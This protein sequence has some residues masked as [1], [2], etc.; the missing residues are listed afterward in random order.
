MVQG[1][2]EKEKERGA[3]SETLV[4]LE[5]TKLSDGRILS[6]I[7]FEKLENKITEYFSN[8]PQPPQ[9]KALS[10]LP[11]L[12]EGPFIV[13]EAH[14]DISPKKF[15]IENMKKFKQYGFEVLFLEHLFYDSDQKDLD[16]FFETG[17]MSLA[18]KSR[19]ATLDN[20]GGIHSNPPDPEIPQ[21]L[22]KQNNYTA[23]VKAAQAAG[24]RIVGAD[25]S[26]LYEAQNIENKAVLNAGNPLDDKRTAYGNYGISQTISHEIGGSNEKWFALLGNTHVNTFKNIPGVANITGA[27]SIYIA[28]EKNWK[29]K[30]IAENSLPSKEVKLNSE[31]V[32][33]VMHEQVKFRGDAII[34][35]H[36]LA[37]ISLFK[38]QEKVDQFIEE[39]R[40]SF[41]KEHWKKY[42]DVKD[43]KDLEDKSKLNIKEAAVLSL[44]KAI[45]TIKTNPYITLEEAKEKLFKPIL[46]VIDKSKERQKHDFT[47]FN[48]KVV[49]QFKDSKVAENLLNFVN[50]N[51]LSTQHVPTK[52][53]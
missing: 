4:P 1:A 5:K 52:T 43:V 51:Y 11:Q 13:G 38:E 50:E 28:D 16:S 30:K 10:T 17:E 14:T 35:Q 22:W 37:K 45:N 48:R 40:G 53:R 6:D 34:T 21:K 39:L 12:V 36:P 33:D 27:K 9:K 23:L 8:I 18:L 26:K 49:F 42:F 19:L 24:I 25:V 29:A 7:H 47:F 32:I 41:P 2:D 15:L 31:R 46:E 3:F 44:V 20:Y